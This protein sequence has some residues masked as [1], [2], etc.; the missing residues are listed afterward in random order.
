MKERDF[1]TQFGK[2]NRIHGCFELKFCK[3]KSLPFNSLA[4]HQEEALLNVSGNGLYHKISDFPVFANSG[5]RFN[6]PKPF[7][8]FYLSHTM[9]YVVIMVWVPRKKKNVYYVKIEDW[10]RMRENATRK[11]AT[12]EML[13]KNATIFEDYTK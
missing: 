7:D 8:A 4:E 3:G 6:R 10:I 12:E 13:F 11:S 2:R 1:Q 9:A 5:A